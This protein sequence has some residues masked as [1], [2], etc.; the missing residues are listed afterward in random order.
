MLYLDEFGVL[1]FSFWIRLCLCRGRTFVMLLLGYICGV[2]VFI[3]VK[4]NRHCRLSAGLFTVEF[5]ELNFSL[6]LRL[7]HTSLRLA[8]Y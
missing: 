8:D 4:T 5:L 1:R 6:V 3:L 2:L 7:V